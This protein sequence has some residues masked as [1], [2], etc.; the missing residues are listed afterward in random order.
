M[1]QKAIKFNN[2]VGHKIRRLQQ[3]AVA[4]F[5]ENVREHAVTPVQ[6]AALQSISDAPG[7]DQKTLADRIRFD[8][9][10]IG[11]VI[12]RLEARGLVAR[13]D[14]QADRRVRLLCLT[15]AG[16]ALL[17]ELQPLV[18]ETQ[19]NIAAALSAAEQKTLETLIDKVLAAHEA[20]N[21]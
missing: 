10:T 20:R 12:D 2:L 18:L 1:P 21:S 8:T 13:S 11:G 5:A 14:S 6:F 3:I 4:V 7:L 17:A 15:G 16:A 19:R 9:S